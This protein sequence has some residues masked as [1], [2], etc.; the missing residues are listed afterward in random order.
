MGRETRRRQAGLRRDGARPRKG[1]SDEGHG[2]HPPHAEKT[3]GRPRHEALQ[4]GLR[5]RPR[6]SLFRSHHVQRQRPR[7]DQSHHGRRKRLFPRN[8]VEVLH[9]Q[10]PLHLPLRLR[11]RL[12]LHP[13]R[14]QGKNQNPRRTRQVPSGNGSQRRPKK[15]ATKGPRRRLRGQTT[16]R[17]RHTAPE[18]TPR[19]S[20]TTRGDTPKKKQTPTAK[21]RRRRRKNN[22]QQIKP[23]HKSQPATRERKPSL[24]S[25]LLC[26]F[27]KLPSSSVPSPSLSLS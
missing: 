21:L 23:S 19:T 14:H 10:R 5:H 7:D 13:P 8:H 4:A 6:R 9:H 11:H 12:A 26:P 16:P 3:H 15:P 20:T 25:S 24:P 22:K 18:G 17:H 1:R 27:L 2:G